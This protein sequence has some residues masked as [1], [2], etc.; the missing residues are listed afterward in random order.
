MQWVYRSA[1][2]RNIPG[3]T[4]GFGGYPRKS[5]ENLKIG[6]LGFYKTPGSEDN[7]IG[8]YAGVDEY[9]NDTWIHCAGSTGSTIGTGNFKYYV[10]LL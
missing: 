5:K 9:G 1:I 10:S 2:G 8:I 6:D 3:S 4:A 7:H